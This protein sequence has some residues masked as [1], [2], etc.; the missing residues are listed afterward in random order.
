MMK[1]VLT[2]FMKSAVY[3]YLEEKFNYVFSPHVPKHNFSLIESISYFEFVLY[4][5]I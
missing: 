2:K 5:D 4:I 1:I 3:M